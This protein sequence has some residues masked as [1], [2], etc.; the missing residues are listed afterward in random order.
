MSGTELGYAA[1]RRWIFSEGKKFKKTVSALR[2]CSAKSNPGIHD[3]SYAVRGT[4]LLYAT[5]R[6]AVLTYRTLLTYSVLCGV[7]YCPS[8]CYALCG[9]E[10][11]YGATR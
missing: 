11:A 10:R 1:V 9:T 7:R 6:Y 3:F 4:D 2:P 8:G 5:T